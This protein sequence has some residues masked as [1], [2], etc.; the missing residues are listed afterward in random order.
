MSEPRDEEQGEASRS[1]RLRAQLFGPDRD[2]D[3]QPD[4]DPQV[5]DVLRE[6]PDLVLHLLGDRPT[7]ALARSWWRHRIDHR[8]VY[9]SVV[10]ALGDL[11]TTAWALDIGHREANPVASWMQ[12]EFG[13]WTYGL[14]LAPFVLLRGT[15]AGLSGTRFRFAL[16]RVLC[17]TIITM[18]AV[19]VCNNL[20]VITGTP[21]LQKI[22]G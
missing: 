10:I 2:G 5:L 17:R 3:G 19:V 20:G 15:L 12:R 9:A 6:D 11:A 21:V 1:R 18:H 13:V 22:F 8:W 16:G 14:A 4:L 7:R